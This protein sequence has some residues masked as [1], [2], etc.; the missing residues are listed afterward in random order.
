M[1]IPL[2]ICLTVM[3]NFVMVCPYQTSYSIGLTDCV[4]TALAAKYRLGK[5]PPMPNIQCRIID[6]EVRISGATQRYTPDLTSELCF[7]LL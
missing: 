6:P 7:F 4:F 3:S 2:T 1:G 5:A